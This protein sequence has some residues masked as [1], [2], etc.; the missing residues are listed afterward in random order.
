MNIF[1]PKFKDIYIDDIIEA[2]RNKIRGR[3]RCILKGPDG[4]IKQQTDWQDNLVTDRGTSRFRWADWASQ[5]AVGTGTTPPAF[6]DT[7]LDNAIGLAQSQAVPGGHSNSG[8]PNYIRTTTRKFVYG[9][10]VATGTLTEI[11]Q[12]EDSNLPVTGNLNTRVLLDVPIVK[13]ALDELTIEYQYIFYPDITD[14][15]GVINIAGEDFDYTIR[16]M[17]LD[18]V[19]H[20]EYAGSPSI[21]IGGYTDHRVFPGSIR[22][23]T[24]YPDDSGGSGLP[25]FGTPTV[26][27]GGSL[28]NYYIDGEM[29]WNLDNA[30]NNNVIKSFSMMM[31][32]GAWLG[33]YGTNPG[34]QAEIG[35]VSDGT[36]ILKENTHVFVFKYR[37]YGDRYP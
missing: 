21:A 30:Y 9:Q 1:I 23:I 11:G 37:V 35:R 25:E 4:K 34:W 6:T 5:L 15:T 36:G 31:P 3:V 2:P 20:W 29:V 14:T 32:W 16:G 7:D 26:T 33:N 24:L 12:T 10:G 19:P 17:N 8:A 13:G 22:D 27:Y 18:H 28:G